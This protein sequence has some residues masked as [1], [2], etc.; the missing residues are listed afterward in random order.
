[1]VISGDPWSNQGRS[2]GW[3]QC[4]LWN[5]SDRSRQFLP[6]SNPSEGE[7]CRL[8]QQWDG[9]GIPPSLW[10]TSQRSFVRVKYGSFSYTDALIWSQSCLE[11]KYWR[12]YETNFSS[13]N[14]SVIK[15][16]ALKIANVWS[17]AVS[18]HHQQMAARDP[19]FFT[20]LPIQP[21]FSQGTS[22]TNSAWFFQPFWSCPCHQAAIWCVQ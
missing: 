12:I 7:V 1:M 9:V 13:P 14:K 19:S 17:T 8:G 4:V 18:G 22:T 6:P 15:Q 16:V 5:P 21:S 11:I 3:E 2:K 10:S 20:N